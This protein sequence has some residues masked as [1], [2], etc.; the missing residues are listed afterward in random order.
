MVMWWS[1]DGHVTVMW[2]SCDELCM[3]VYYRFSTFKPVLKDQTRVHLPSLAS[4]ASYSVTQENLSCTYPSSWCWWSQIS[5]PGA[6]LSAVQLRGTALHA[7]A[8]LPN[9]I[10]YR[11]ILSWTCLVC[12][13][14][15]N[16]TELIYSHMQSYTTVYSAG[17]ASILTSSTFCTV[18]Q[19]TRT[20]G[21]GV[22]LSISSSCF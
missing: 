2:Q 1:C 21:A 19:N 14:I 7:T 16:Y 5:R 9:I 18:L 13:G 20:G 22:L 15:Q 17:H 11:V 6:S 8:P 12:R 10:V 3:L 4:L